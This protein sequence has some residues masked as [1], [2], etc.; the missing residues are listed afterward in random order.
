MARYPD[1]P[2]RDLKMAEI[3]KLALEDW[4]RPDPPPK[5]ASLK[6]V[7]ESFRGNLAL[8]RQ[9]MLLPTSIA[10]LAMLTER[11]H[12][13]AEFELTGKVIRDSHS[14]PE[15][16]LAKIDQQRIEELDA[17]NRAIQER[18]VGP[19][20]DAHARKFHDDAAYALQGLVK[21][22]MGAMGFL[23]ILVACTTGT[24]TA[25][26]TMLGDLWE[27]ALNAHPKLLAALKGRASRIGGKVPKSEQINEGEQID[28]IEHKVIPIHLLERF[29]FD[30][31]SHMGTIIRLHRRF[32]F[33]KL[34]SIR[35][36]YSCAFSEKA[37]RIDAALGSK[38]LDSLSAVRNVV[39]HKASKADE[40]YIRKSKLLTDL[41]KATLGMPIHLDG[42]I[43][44]KL[45]RDAVKSSENLIHAVDHWISEY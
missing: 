23:P 18:Y 17:H 31:R 32:E 9:L 34:S 45:V 6:G 20:W 7:T 21:T 36:A 26:E 38:S 39:V 1:F 15:E 14:L 13:I 42:E 2:V 33:T 4:E 16:I 43:V 8:V 40:E 27:A 28:Q 3:A 11:V 12:A 24:W 25:I 10:G 41:P 30:P 44:S 22:P 5:Q 37:G 29:Q 19:D 35:E